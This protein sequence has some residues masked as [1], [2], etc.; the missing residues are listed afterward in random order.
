MQLEFATVR[1]VSG[2]VARTRLFAATRMARKE[3]LV[4]Q[5]L[6]GLSRV[7]WNVQTHSHVAVLALAF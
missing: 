4:A 3:A 2:P 6:A 7:D 5:L 1:T